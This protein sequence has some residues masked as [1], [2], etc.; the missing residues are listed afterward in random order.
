MKS[1]R[2]AFFGALNGF[3]SV[4]FGAFG[5]HALRGRIDERLFEVF[6]TAVH[7]HGM[8]ALALL[9]VGIWVAAGGSVWVRRSGWLFA[10]GI[11]LFCGSLYLLALGGASAWGLVT[12]FGGLAFLGG[13]AA[14]AAAAYRDGR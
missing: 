2:F 7:Y 10:L 8:H 13:W 12:P 4:A 11:L 6:Q 9:A 3:L 1:S 5:A 14:L